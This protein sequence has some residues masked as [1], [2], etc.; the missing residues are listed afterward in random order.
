M[1]GVE[2][3]KNYKQ[4]QEAFKPKGVDGTFSRGG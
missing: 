3:K 2:K 4:F 1:I